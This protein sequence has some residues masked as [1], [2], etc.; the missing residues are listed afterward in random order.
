[1]HQFFIHLSKGIRKYINN[2]I[3]YSTE[4]KNPPMFFKVAL[5]FSW[6][7]VTLS[8]CIFIAWS[9]RLLSV[10]LVFR[11]CL[12]AD[13][14]NCTSPWHGPDAQFSLQLRCIPSS[15]GRPNASSRALHLLSTALVVMEIYLIQRT[16]GLNK[17]TFRGARTAAKHVNTCWMPGT[18][19]GMK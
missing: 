7:H 14:M 10:L 18:T 19:D 13:P 8:I 9:F 11:W 16:I 4:N 6:S 15:R 1:M 5:F 2:N 17:Y 12:Q 3:V